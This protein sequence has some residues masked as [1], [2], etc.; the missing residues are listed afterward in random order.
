MHSSGRVG[1]GC[2]PAD[3]TAVPHHRKPVPTFAEYVP[4]VSAAVSDGNRRAA[5]ATGDDPGL[6][7]LLRL[8]TETACRRGDASRSAQR[9]SIRTSA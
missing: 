4:V 1:M 5:A 9:I 3:L 2:S 7:T 6:D 8:D